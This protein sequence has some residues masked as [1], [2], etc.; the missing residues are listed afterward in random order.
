MKPGA[1]V[2]RGSLVPASRGHPLAAKMPD[3][4]L[5]GRPNDQGS[6]PMP[7]ESAHPLKPLPNRPLRSFLKTD[8]DSEDE[9]PVVLHAGGGKNRP[10]VVV[11]AGS[12]SEDGCADESDGSSSRSRRCAPIGQLTVR[13]QPSSRIELLASTEERSTGKSSVADTSETAKATRAVERAADAIKGELNA[14]KF[15][16]S[17]E[18]D[19]DL[20]AEQVKLQDKYIAWAA[21]LREKRERHLRNPLD[22]RFDDSYQSWGTTLKAAFSNGRTAFWRSALRQAAHNA[23]TT[24][25]APGSGLPGEL[26]NRADSQS[27]GGTA[28]AV[29]SFLHEHLTSVALE[30]P[31]AKLNIPRLKAIPVDDL[32]PMPGPVCLHVSGDGRLKHFYR[33]KE[34]DLPGQH[35]D[36]MP[37]RPQLEDRVRR[38]RNKHRKLQAALDQRHV[39]SASRAILSGLTNVARRVALSAEDLKS[40]WIVGLTSML[41]SG[42]AVF[43]SEFVLTA[44]KAATSV[45]MDNLAGGKAS[46][47]LFAPDYPRDDDG[48]PSWNEV[49][50]EAPA[51]GLKQLPRRFVA[52]LEAIRHE[53]FAAGTDWFARHV[54]V[55]IGSGVFGL[56]YGAVLSSILSNGN[57]NGDP[58]ESAHSAHAMVLQ[59]INSG[60]A[61]WIREPLS[62]TV[63][64]LKFDVNAALRALRDIA[65]VDAQDSGAPA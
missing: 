50:W 18:G 57:L 61:N 60:A 43:A 8:S 53:P 35:A 38:E 28:A 64:D 4:P 3:P 44:A 47:P 36:G 7:S 58:D 6:A 41:A 65:A 33:P 23:V 55:N 5:A 56:G 11:T 15:R 30:P 34:R 2:K 52:L 12:G 9:S 1:L 29:P 20:E 17:I 37:T 63:T 46:T 42:G 14:L 19:D 54:L 27:V 39:G 21:P 45:S 13:R 62:R 40:P 59:G 32:H 22:A 26:N 10:S 24:A 51:S 25:L 49:L 31:A 48:P 16:P